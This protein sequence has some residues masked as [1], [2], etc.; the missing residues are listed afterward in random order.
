MQDRYEMNIALMASY[1][2]YAAWAGVLLYTIHYIHYITRLTTNVS[3]AE[4]EESEFI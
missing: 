2:M 3:W 1:C 4:G